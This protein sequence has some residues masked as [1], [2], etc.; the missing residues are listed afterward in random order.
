MRRADQVALLPVCAVP[1]RSAGEVVMK[2]RTKERMME[3]GV[4]RITQYD[5]G[6]RR[7]EVKLSDTLRVGDCIH[8]KGLRSDWW[9]PVKTIRVDEKPVAKA[10]A[11]ELAWL[12]VIR[13]AYEG[14][15]VLVLLT[16][17]SVPVPCPELSPGPPLGPAPDPEPHHPGPGKPQPLPGP[18]KEPKS[19]PEPKPKR[20]K[21]DDP[22]LEIELPEWPKKKNNEEENEDE[23]ED[24]PNEDEGPDL[25]HPGN[26]GIDN[27]EKGKGGGEGG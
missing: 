10:R 23:D 11:A 2:K 19:S 27:K 25:P 16:M 8:I 21:R 15:E 14:D 26:F 9:Q 4:G 1:G 22:D 18:G 7:A 17:N 5:A 12:E 3:R 6:R 13:R 20:P 24:E